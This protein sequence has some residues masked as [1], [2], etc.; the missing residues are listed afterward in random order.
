MRH[1][2]LQLPKRQRGAVAVVVG[3]TIF[4][5]VGMIGLA[6]DS[7]QLFVN[8]TELQN[9]ADA[10]ALAAARELDGNADALIRADSV[11]VFVGKQNL[12]GFQSG[13]VQ[14]TAADLSYSAHLSPNSDYQTSANAD[15]GTARF[16]MCE[17]ERNNIG[18]WFMGVRGFGDQTVSAY[19]V[20][21]VLPAQ[22]SC[23]LPIG[24]CKNYTPPA[25]CLD[26]GVPDKNGL[27]VGEWRN[28]R[29]EAKDGSFG[30][31]NWIDFVDK[32][33]GTS[34]LSELLI[35]GLC[36]IPDVSEVKYA[37]PG[38]AQAAAKAWNSRF[39]LYPP[40]GGNGNPSPTGTPPATADWTGYSYTTTSEG[41][42]AWPAQRNAFADF[43]EHRV[44]NDPYQ[45]DKETG[46]QLTGNYTS[47][48]APAGDRRVV[49][50]PIIDCTSWG[51][52][53][54]VVIED[55][56]CVLM[57]HPIGNPS[58]EDVY[59]EYRGLASTP[60]S[61]CASYGLAGGTIGPLIPVLVQ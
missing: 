2:P 42:V 44:T 12:V 28:G 32:N 20:A 4:V 23:A 36:E 31:F 55:W 27:C 15:A 7:G 52:S 24:F 5:L 30:A 61:P 11:G 45:G 10:C 1:Q 54:Q 18:M 8:K 58:S 9:A 41:K 38:I 3:L 53:K 56:A 13:A 6:L 16:V 39:G 46:L 51:P 43:L 29:F 59:M 37:E 50:V 49:P 22:T 35:T 60:G 48:E 19:A 26:G 14:L 34:D 25:N 21:T 40:G 33:G 17:V 57:L 47:I